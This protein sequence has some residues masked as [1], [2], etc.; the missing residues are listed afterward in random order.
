MAGLGWQGQW[1]AP[2][3]TR[4]RDIAIIVYTLE[5]TGNKWNKRWLDFYKTAGGH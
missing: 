3:Q 2:A 1:Q 5:N 4:H